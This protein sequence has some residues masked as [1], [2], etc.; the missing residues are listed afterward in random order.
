MYRLD[1][2]KIKAVWAGWSPHDIFN[3]IKAPTDL[4]YERK[5]FT[6]LRDDFRKYMLKT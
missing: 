2:R 6:P 1:S 5:T 3:L 4:V